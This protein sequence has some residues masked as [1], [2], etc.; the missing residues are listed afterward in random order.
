MEENQNTYDKDIQSQ[1]SHATHVPNNLNPAAIDINIIN[2][3]SLHHPSSNDFIDKDFK[4][5]VENENDQNLNYA[6]TTPNEKIRKASC[7]ISL[8]ET[9]IN[10][11]KETQQIRTNEDSSFSRCTFENSR[12]NRTIIPENDEF[13]RAPC[14]K[15]KIS[16]TTKKYKYIGDT[17]NEKRDGFGV[18]D[19]LNGKV[20]IGMFRND[21]RNGYGKI[22]H[23]NGDVEYAEYSDDKMDGYYECIKKDGVRIESYIKTKKFSDFIVFEKNNITY[24]GE[25]QANENSNL[26][27]GKLTI[28]KEDSKKVFIGNVLNYQ[29][30]YGTG[31]FY[32]DNTLFYGEI[33]NKTMVNY[34][35]NYS[36]DAGCFLGFLI[37][38]KKNGV[39]LSFL[40]D[41]R[42]CIGEFED[43]QKKGPIFIFTNPKQGVKMELYLMGFK[44]KTVE[45]M[46]TIKKYL[47]LNY[48]EYCNILKIDF[49][50]LINKLSRDVNE[51]IAN[52]SK[53]IEN[54]K[55]E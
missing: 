9:E 55:N 49:E 14:E 5:P 33:K 1:N 10:K 48:P 21:M 29:T 23:P 28:K 24:Q 31:L 46:D 8:F 47:Q 45:K 27:F 40:K 34:I 44:T 39:G 11:E 42:V 51:E 12:D 15:I 50:K 16:F 3:S 26:S 35:E 2:I 53:M 19:F 7:D 52:S 4:Q 36:N 17:L 41:G 22:I 54:Y 38:S 37:D 13:S 18:C 30:E 32:K 25:P 20:Y 43:D 6:Q